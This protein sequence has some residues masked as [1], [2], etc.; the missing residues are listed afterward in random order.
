MY[1]NHYHHHYQQPYSLIYSSLMDRLMKM[2]RLDSTLDFDKELC[3]LTSS[4]I[5]FFAPGS[6]TI[7]DL[8]QEIQSAAQDE[9]LTA[10][11]QEE[12]KGHGG[13]EEQEEGEEEEGEEEGEETHPT[14]TPQRH[15]SIS[16][17]GKGKDRKS[18]RKEK[19]GGGGGDDEEEEEEGA[20]I[21][22]VDP[23]EEGKE[24]GDKQSITRTASVSEVK[25]PLA[26]PMKM[27]RHRSSKQEEKRKSKGN[28]THSFI[29][30]PSTD[31]L[32]WKQDVQV[33]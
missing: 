16:S 2:E 33:V 8:Q 17:K 14:T 26:S 5:P 4:L 3:T 23:S 21:S 24:G 29:G 15:S 13:Q 1:F 19:E 27:N 10:I 7:M 30:A 31:Y 25:T 6:L 22:M 28:F 32:F 12:K 9:D 18:T 20:V 11:I